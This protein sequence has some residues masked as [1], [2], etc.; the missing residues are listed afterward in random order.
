[1]A[2]LGVAVGE[3]DDFLNP[4]LRATMSDPKSLKDCTV[5]AKL[6]MEATEGTRAVAIFADYDVDGGSSAALLFDF[7]HIFSSNQHSTF[8]IELM[9][10]MAQTQKQCRNLQVSTILLFAWTVGPFHM[11]HLHRRLKQML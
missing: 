2:R 1:M 5:A 3:V 4:T 8:L 7:L 11:M 6:I 9:K 10:A